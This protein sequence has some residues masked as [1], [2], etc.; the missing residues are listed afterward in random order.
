MRAKPSLPFVR[1]VHFTM[2]ETLRYRRETGKRCVFCHTSIPEQGDEN[3]QLNQDGKRFQENG[4]E[5]T[6]EQKRKPELDGPD[7]AKRPNFPYS[8]F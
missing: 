4:H 8:F 6:E 1:I 5:L 3:P 7:L 2:E